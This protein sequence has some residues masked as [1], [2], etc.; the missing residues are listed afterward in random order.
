MGI[1]GWSLLTNTSNRRSPVLAWTKIA[2]SSKLRV[3]ASNLASFL[4]SSPLNAPIAIP[5][6]RLRNRVQPEQ[7]GPRSRRKQQYFYFNARPSDGAIEQCFRD[8][9]PAHKRRAR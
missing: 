3:V 9:E 6:E 2:R 8:C 5:L 7:P 4:M 1:L